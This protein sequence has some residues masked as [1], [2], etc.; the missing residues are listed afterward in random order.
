MRP[1][2]PFHYRICSQFAI[3]WP[4]G[5]SAGRWAPW[6]CGRLSAD[7]YI[8]PVAGRELFDPADFADAGISL[9]F[10]DLASFIYDLPYN[11]EKD[12]SI[13]DVLMWN[14]PDAIVQGIRRNSSLISILGQESGGEGS[15]V[16]QI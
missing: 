15:R 10:L 3:D 13:L 11:F 12:L 5:L 9:E 4:D 8:D 6:I 16:I 7:V 2:L 1:G 14:S